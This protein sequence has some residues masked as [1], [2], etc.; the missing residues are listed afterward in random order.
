MPGA[1]AIF[2][3]P[4][5]SDGGFAVGYDSANRLRQYQRGVLSSA[6]IP[7]LVNAGAAI[8]T[9]T[10]L[11][12][13]DQ[14]RTY[15]LDGLGNWKTTN[16]TLVGSG[17]STTSTAEVRQHN[18]VNE[19]T[20]V[21]DTTGGTPAT[22][23]FTYDRNGNLLNDGERIYKY[24]ALNRL[25][26]INKVSGG[27]LIATYVYDGMN[28]RIQKN[29]ND[30]GGG[31]GGLTGDIPAGTVNYL[32]D[33][34]QIAL[35]RD[36]ESNWMQAYFWG[37][38]IDELLFF[39]VPTETVPTTYRVLSDLLYRSV[40]IVTTSNVVTEA[41]DTDAYGNTL[42]Y[43]G[44]GTDDEWFTDDYVRTNN[45]IN[46]TIF[47][48]RQYDPESQI[49]YYRAR[50]YSSEIGRFI[51]RDPIGEEGGINL[52]EYVKNAPIKW[53]DPSGLCCT[54]SDYKSLLDQLQTAAQMQSSLYGNPPPTY[55]GW[56]NPENAHHGEF[57]NLWNIWGNQISQLWKQIHD[58]EKNACRYDGSNESW[59]QCTE[60]AAN[61]AF[62]EFADKVFGQV[63]DEALKAIVEKTAGKVA[64]EWLEKVMS[65]T[66]TESVKVIY[67]I[68]NCEIKCFKGNNNE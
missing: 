28:R 50:Y 9:P 27:G 65:G 18:Y 46:S 48:G 59:E 62:G 41:Y 35:E 66:A 58:C 57:V 11:P 20:S 60:C 61:C 7:Y 64:R 40:A 67:G 34:Q 49:Y 30:L 13:A 25:V 37:Q 26:Q 14:A 45:P 21:K 68:L 3:Q 63:K 52:F 51:S 4:F 1:A 6:T 22:T 12:G 42:C 2:T 44:P 43:S 10:T 36:D 19:I 53:L 54:S 39:A 16:F 24:D 33:G 23:G 31:M 56:W 32:Y 47:T 5:N 55:A 15:G 17:G 29:I 38:Y 8:S